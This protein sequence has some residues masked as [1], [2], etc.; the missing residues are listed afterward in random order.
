MDYEELAQTGDMEFAS[1]ECLSVALEDQVDENPDEILKALK[2]DPVPGVNDR[3]VWRWR[4]RID[5]SLKRMP[6]TRERL[7]ALK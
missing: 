1:F 2:F 3:Q 6:E 4:E 5:A 7:E